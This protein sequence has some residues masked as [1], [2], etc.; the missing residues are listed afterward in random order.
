MPK[1]RARISDSN[2]LTR[3]DGVI[4]RYEQAANQSGETEAASQQI[5][6]SNSQKAD[7]P[8]SQEASKLASQQ[9]DNPTKIAATPDP[10]QDRLANQPVDKL[11]SQ[12]V[13]N[14]TS[15]QVS[16]SN[17]RAADNSIDNDRANAVSQPT[18]QEADKLTSQQ[19]TLGQ[20]IE[21]QNSIS[22]SQQADK[23]M[24]KKA[25]FKLDSDVL[26][27]LDRYHLQL[28][29]T[30]G[31][32]ATPYKE[33]IVE[34]AIAQWLERSEKAGDRTIKSLVKRQQRRQD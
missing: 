21:R 34:E 23:L 5:N 1:P 7:L 20:E 32:Q 17:E 24:L 13:N 30:L 22:T 3:T 31:K 18:S 15:Q 16:K 10:Q 25:T 29:L 2:P 33:T 14:L 28:Q 9:V 27:M 8:T 19:V 6:K 26:A 4:D 11:E 12:Q